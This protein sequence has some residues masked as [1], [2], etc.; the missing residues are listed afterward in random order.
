MFKRLRYSFVLAVLLLCTTQAIAQIAMPDSVCIGTTRIYS[1]TSLA[2]TST[3]TWKVD[4]VTQAS[5]TNKISITWNTAGTYLLTLQERSAAGCDGDIKS[6]LVYVSP[7]PV[8]NAGP[9]TVICFG[10]NGA[11]DGSGGN[12]YQWSPV[13]YLSNPA[14]KN[15]IIVAPPTGILEYVLKVTNTIGCT[16][17]NSD[18]VKIRV[19]APLKVFAGRDTVLP[20]N[21]PVTLNAVDVNNAGF[22][23]YLWSPTNGLNNPFIK[24]P[25]AIV[26]TDITYTVTASTANGCDA[27]DDIVLKVFSI[28]E[29][30]VPT[31]FSPNGYNKLLHAIPV[32]IKEFRYFSIF[33]RWGKEVFRT[34]NPAEGWDGNYNGVAQNIGGYVW[35]AEGVDYK[36]RVISRKGNVVLL[37]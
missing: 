21:Q 26:S 5:V 28:A 27:T 23:A 10:N 13:D 33:N 19:T 3:Y 6:G 15:P 7:V 30:Y 32:G 9:D 8:A 16:S 31:A 34:S 37:R 1:V 36:N 18:T 11:L 25:V 17:L 22:T 24:N 29:I 12:R 35:I 2:T 4:G 20:I 14:I